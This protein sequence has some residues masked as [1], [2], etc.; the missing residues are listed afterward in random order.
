MKKWKMVAS[1]L[2]LCCMFSSLQALHR[3]TQDANDPGKPA[4]IKV[5]LC[6]ESEGVLLE[7]RGSFEVINP[8]NGKRVSSGRKGK[9]FYL[10]PHKEGIKWGENFLGIFQLQ[11]V[12]TH[13]STTFLIDGVQYRGSIEVYHIEDT[14]SIINETDVESFLKATLPEKITTSQP[15]AVL[16]SIAII[17]RTDAYYLALLNHEAFWHV[18]AQQ[19]HYQ[20]SGLTLQNLEIDRAVDNTRH[21]IM[22]FEEQPFPATWTE[23]CAG[24]TAN[25]QNIFRKNTP[26]P[27]GVESIF[28][29]RDR[30][31]THWTFTIDNQELAKVAKINRVTRID[32]FVDHQS[33]KVYAIRIN[34]GTHTEDIDFMTFQE[35]L[36]EEKLCSN[37]FTVSIK[38]NIATFEGYGRGSGVGL[39][40]YSA[41]NMSE[42]GD[43]TPEILAEFFPYTHLEKMR[44]YPRAI[45]SAD[46]GS[47][48]SPK[49]KKAAEKKY[50][51]L[52]K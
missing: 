33:N 3:E 5:L 15:P 38:G 2:M 35:Y 6:K 20:G 39:C 49:Q 51:I 42:R 27:A 30:S 28:A 41:K 10:Y 13:A 21:L 48:V 44:S 17:A 32:L 31:D 52:H 14:L 25:Y 18:T 47:F 16:D 23:H 34:D 24:K 37:D 11:I 22:T 7:A 36:G 4:T 12:P 19:S 46:K 9:R 8:E 50:K 1:F 43:A 40:L 26:T 29:L 45:V